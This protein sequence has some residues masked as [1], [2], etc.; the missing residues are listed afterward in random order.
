[1]RWL[2]P[3]R[4]YLE[5]HLLI[6]LLLGFA[7][8]LP[9]ALVGATLT[10]RLAETG[11]S[12]ETIGFFA[13]VGMAYG[14][15][16]LWAPAIDQLPLPLLTPW[17]GRR[18]AWLFVIQILLIL[19]L[20]GLG[21]TDPTAG[22]APVA[23]W[24]LIAAFLAASQDIVIDAYRVEILEE[25][26]QAAG[27]A[28]ITVGY[29]VAM[30]V[31]GAGT[32]VMAELWGWSAAYALTGMLLLIGLAAGLLQGEPAVPPGAHGIQTRDL[33]ATLR[34]GVVEPF[35]E[36]FTRN[37]I[38]TAFVIL[39]FIMLYKLGDAV[40]G[41]VTSPLYVELGFTKTEVATIVKSWGLGA[42]LV[43][44]I[45][46]GA[47]VRARGLLPGLWICG[48][49]Q[50]ISNLAYILLVWAGHDTGI[51]ALAIAVENLT[52]G[53]GTA[54]FVGYLASLCNLTYTATQ[55]ALLSSF[56]A[57]GR[58]FFAGFSGALAASIGWIPFFVAT[59]VM[60]APALMILVWLQRRVA[61]PPVDE[62]RGAPGLAA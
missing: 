14:W 47:I 16:F 4:I 62:G 1:M 18:R 61:T 42:T 57:Q 26:Q 60:A 53:M 23:F 55:Y 51:L 15:K 40:L 19:A 6:V 33:R 13:W 20:V 9:L 27:A 43:G 2:A 38:V 28:A 29:R 3:F 48:I 5:R 7:S 36:F 59:T 50:M 34:A 32:L 39:L 52:G 45:L 41:A 44:V 31:S 58:T 10:F 46:G 17:L 21:A 35:A 56:M 37:G 54:A 22:I 12:L 11:V 25:R 49:A 30:L 24:A 8:G